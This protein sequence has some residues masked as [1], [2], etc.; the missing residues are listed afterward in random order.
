MSDILTLPAKDAPASLFTDLVYEI[1]IS[2]GLK[3]ASDP[4]PLIQRLA[5]EIHKG[6][7]PEATVNQVLTATLKATCKMFKIEYSFDR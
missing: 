4:K 5:Q 1:L 3:F 2:Q 7:H 6:A